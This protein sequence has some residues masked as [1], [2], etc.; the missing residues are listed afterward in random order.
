MSDEEELKT[1]HKVNNNDNNNIVT[2]SSMTMTSKMKDIDYEVKVTPNT[3]IN[4]KIVRA[5]KKLQASYNDSASKIIE[6]VQKEKM[7]SKI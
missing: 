3:T 4:A 5:M 6:Q 7:P 2:D 1:V